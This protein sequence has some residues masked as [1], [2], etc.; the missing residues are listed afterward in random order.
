MLAYVDDPC[1]QKILTP[2]KGD[3]SG[4]QDAL[5]RFQAGDVKVTRQS[6]GEPAI[7]VVQRIRVFLGFSTSSRGGYSIADGA[8]QDRQCRQ[9]VY[10]HH[11]RVRNAKQ[12]NSPS[13][14][15]YMSTLS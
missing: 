1:T 14:L 9:H 7:R 3:N 13:R 4:L 15:S 10:R 2:S 12:K 8:H 6:V 5:R 11:G